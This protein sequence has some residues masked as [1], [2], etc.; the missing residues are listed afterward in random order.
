VGAEPSAHWQP[1]DCP[2]AQS[3]AAA[4]C[5]VSELQAPIPIRNA[6]SPLSSRVREPLQRTASAFAVEFSSAFDRIVIVDAR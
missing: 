2:G 6:L 5:C 3:T 1:F 4:S